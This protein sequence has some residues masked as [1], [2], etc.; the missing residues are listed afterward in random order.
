[1]LGFMF[2]QSVIATLLPKSD[3]SP[4]LAEYLLSSLILSTLNLI[5]SAILMLVFNLGKSNSSIVR[6]IERS[7]QRHNT[8]LLRIYSF[9][10]F[11]CKPGSSRSPVRA[12]R[13]QR[14]RDE[15]KIPLKERQTEF[16]SAAQSTECS[17]HS[18]QIDVNDTNSYY[19][20]TR[21]PLLV[22]PESSHVAPIN[23]S[24]F[25]KSQNRGS[26]EEFNKTN[27]ML[28]NRAAKT[29]LIENGDESR[30]MSP[31][32]ASNSY[33]D[34]DSKTGKRRN[35]E[36]ENKKAG[37]EERVPENVERDKTCSKKKRKRHYDQEEF[38]HRMTDFISR[39]S[40]SLLI[41]AQLLVVLFFL[42]PIFV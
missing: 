13:R 19:A 18:L 9:G 28:P 33:N 21:R 41:L 36:N 42:V 12:N 4:L 32:S 17:P 1:M 38:W 40:T 6:R 29:N 27:G 30:T 39:I 26:T 5:V 11:W 22:G 23:V 24:T 8:S 10:L 37:N 7:L 14:E 25:E 35:K 34:G 3:K 31:H 2:I 20:T 15:V 16:L